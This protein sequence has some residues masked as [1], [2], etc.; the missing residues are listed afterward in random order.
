MPSSRQ[1]KGYQTILNGAS[2]SGPDPANRLG[3][4][5]ARVN[6]LFHV[7]SDRF[8]PSIPANGFTLR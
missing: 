6:V 4:L 3:E 2:T 7:Y 1:L 5:K 8:L